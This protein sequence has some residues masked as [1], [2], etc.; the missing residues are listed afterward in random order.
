MTQRTPTFTKEIAKRAK[1]KDLPEIKKHLDKYDICLPRN[2]KDYKIARPEIL[3]SEISK[4]TTKQAN[5]CIRYYNTLKYNLIQKIHKKSQLEDIIAKIDNL[6]NIRWRI[7]T[8]NRDLVFKFISRHNMEFDNLYM[9][10]IYK[11]IDRF[12]PDLNYSPSTYF[13]KVLK[14]DRHRYYNGNANQRNLS[15]EFDNQVIDIACDQLILESID[16][17][18]SIDYML[19]K[20]KFLEDNEKRVIQGRFFDDLTLKD[21]GIKE[22]VSRERIRQIEQK[23]IDK[24]RYYCGSVL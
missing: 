21:L 18:Q 12:N 5:I 17:K 4:S 11:S 2:A 6:V 7:V 19:D 24:L 9:I 16:K 8:I 15:L 10:S 3:D 22:G 20:F 23:A 14:G 13:W 1:Q